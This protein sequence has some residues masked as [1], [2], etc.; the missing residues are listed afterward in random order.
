M[1][2]LVCRNI[3]GEP[4]N[5]SAPIQ[6]HGGFWV[7]PLCRLLAAVYFGRPRVFGCANL[8][9]GAALLASNHR[10]GAVDGM[11]LA[12]AAPRWTFVVGANL[13]RHP[14]LR[15]FVAGLVVERAA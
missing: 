14:L 13:A 9:A 4:Q 12:N 8:P 15:H 1:D 3:A 6:L 5:G 11:L 10:S 2:N 7:R